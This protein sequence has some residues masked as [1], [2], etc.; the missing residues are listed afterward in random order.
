VAASCD[1]SRYVQAALGGDV[2][3]FGEG[4]GR[5]Q[6]VPPDEQLGIAVSARSRRALDGHLRRPRLARPSGSRRLFTSGDGRDALP[7]SG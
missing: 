1:G 4:P 2:L 6:P 3:P 5:G 7:S